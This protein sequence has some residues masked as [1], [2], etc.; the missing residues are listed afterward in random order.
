[1]NDEEV[2]AAFKDLLEQMQK[3]EYQSNL[4]DKVRA[5]QKSYLD[6]KSGGIQSFEEY[7]K[8]LEQEPTNIITELKN[9][10]VDMVCSLI[11]ILNCS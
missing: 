9:L 1:M 10:R 3:E 11:C 7:K 4:V 5:V 6:Y 2:T 8:F